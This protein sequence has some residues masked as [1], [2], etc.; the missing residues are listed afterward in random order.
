MKTEQSSLLGCTFLPAAVVGGAAA[1]G[2]MILGAL[3]WIELSEARDCEAALARG[4][5]ASLEH[6]LLVH[7]NGQCRLTVQTILKGLP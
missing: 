6:Y 7:P 2:A 3:T 1:L 5:R 4:D